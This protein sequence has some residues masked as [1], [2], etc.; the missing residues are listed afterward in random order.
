MRK[1]T[2][3]LVVEGGRRGGGRRSRSRGGKGRGFGMRGIRTRR[4][5]L[6]TRQDTVAR[7]V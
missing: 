4:M 1:S 6:S 7:L 3:G 2:R 5:A